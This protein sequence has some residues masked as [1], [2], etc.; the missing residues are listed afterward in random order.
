MN[1]IIN[2]QLPHHTITQASSPSEGMCFGL[3][4]ARYMNEGQVLLDLG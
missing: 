4:R 3:W 1:A 2:N